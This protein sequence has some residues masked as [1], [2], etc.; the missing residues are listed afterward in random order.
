MDYINEILNLSVELLKYESVY[1]HGGIETDAI[2]GRTIVDCQ[3]EMLSYC[4][5]IGMETYLDP[6]GAYG[7]AQTGPGDEY[8]GILTHLDIVAAGDVNQWDNDPFDPQ[9]KEDKIIAR[10]AA[11]DKV[12]A[13][14][15]AVLVKNLLDTDYPLKYPIRVIFGSDEETGFRGVEKYKKNHPEPKYTLVFDGTFPFSYSE[16]HLMNYSL[17]ID[18]DI[19]IEG[20]VGYN[21][22]MDYVK[23]QN[24]DEEVVAEGVSAHASRPWKGENALVKMAFVNQ[25]KDPLFDVVNQLIEPSGK[26]KL[27]LIDEVELND[28]M[29]VNFGMVKDNIIYTD[30]RIPPEVDVDAFMKRFEG[31]LSDRGVKAEMTDFLRGSKTDIHSEYAKTVLRCY[32]EISGDDT[33]EPFKTGSATYG[34]SFSKNCLSFGPR[35]EYHI[36]NTHK[37]NEFVP[38][39]LIENAFEIYLHTLKSIEEEL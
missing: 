16:K 7:Y 39:D 8:I 29:T 24:G 31:Y 17:H 38:L 11:D 10:G 9:I 1:G 36:T 20:G 13:A 21:S 18:S 30:V 35:M 2:Y 28:D 37:P 23:W 4:E 27:N 15:A 34:R 25:G 22:V 14:I 32:R 33:R 6:E 12:P 3:K 5:S 19:N 26:H